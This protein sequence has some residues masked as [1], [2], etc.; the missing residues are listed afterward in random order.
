MNIFQKD[1]QAEIN[2]LGEKLQSL[3]IDYEQMEHL[4]KWEKKDMLRS[5]FHHVT[6]NF[7]SRLIELTKEL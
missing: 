2:R 5:D 1:L 3:V 7:K 4:S 6:M